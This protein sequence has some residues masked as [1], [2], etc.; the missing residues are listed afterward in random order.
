MR[1]QTVRCNVPLWMQAQKKAPRCVADGNACRLDRDCIWGKRCKDD[2]KEEKDVQRS[3]PSLPRMVYT[4]RIRPMLKG[5][6]RGKYIVA[7]GPA[8][9]TASAAQPPTNLRFM[10]GAA[11]Y[12]NGEEWRDQEREANEQQSLSRGFPLRGRRKEKARQK[13]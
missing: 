10:V 1:H 12:G 11:T 3:K 7:C 4:L 2:G 13:V 6:F 9:S 5:L 8:L